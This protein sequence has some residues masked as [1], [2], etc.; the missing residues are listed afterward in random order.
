LKQKGKNL[1]VI[2][3]LSSAKNQIA[4]ASWRIQKLP[5][6]ERGV[7]SSDDVQSVVFRFS[8]ANKKFHFKWKK[9]EPVD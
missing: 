3:R 5:N 6:L 1:P 7:I 9:V 8:S 2:F 4:S